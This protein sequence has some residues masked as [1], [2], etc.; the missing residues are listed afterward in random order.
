MYRTGDFGKLIK[1][2]CIQYEG[3][4]DSQV[5]VRGHRVELLEIERNL[6][7]VEEVEKGVV[8]CYHSGKED[9]AILAFVV[10][11]KNVSGL[12]SQQANDIENILSTK[13]R[14][15]EIPHVFV[16]ESIPLLP[17]G[18]IDRQKLLNF[19]ENRNQKCKTPNRISL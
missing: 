3:R 11:Q 18:K 10:P 19:Y 17:N 4:A 14:D 12:P 5:K 8:L 2:G 6:R 9:Q 15:I 16:V 13:L 1:E 7:S